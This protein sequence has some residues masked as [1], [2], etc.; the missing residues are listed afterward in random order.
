MRSRLAVAAFAAVAVVAVVAVEVVAVVAV[1]APLTSPVARAAE[2]A[3]AVDVDGLCPGAAAG[4]AALRQRRPTVVVT[5]ARRDR[6]SE[7]RAWAD[8]IARK[9]TWMRILKGWKRPERRAAQVWI[10]AHWRALRGHPEPIAAH[11]ALVF[12]ALSDDDMA[13][14]SPHM[15]GRAV[16]LRKQAGLGRRVL[17]ALPHATAVLD[18]HD[19]WHVA[20]D[21]AEATGR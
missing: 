15:A 2:P 5:S 20:F 18:E 12:A 3:P 8:N 17:R 11:L 4:L 14:L 19:H 16:D 7:A 6:A 1:V 21:C 10:D 13:S 9:R